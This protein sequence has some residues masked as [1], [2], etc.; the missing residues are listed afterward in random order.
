M[1]TLT[2]LLAEVGHA[3]TRFVTLASAIT[4][5]QA[6]FKPSPDA[7]CITENVEHMFWA[8]HGGINGM[9]K[10]FEAYKSGKPLFTGELIHHGL[11]IE[12]IIA[13]TWKEKEIVPEVAKPRLGGP[14]DF[15][16]QALM[17]LQPVLTSFAQ[18][19]KDENLEKIIHPH[20]ISGPLNVIQRFEFL[21]FHLDRHADQIRR[22]KN[23][24]AYPA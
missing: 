19:V 12:S 13:R 16:N 23:D 2:Q 11:S 20:P 24:P 22:I 18:V 6:S 21:R 10:T 9:W 17:S 7:W 14:V 8:E 4:P 1:K 3:R 15:W 5:A